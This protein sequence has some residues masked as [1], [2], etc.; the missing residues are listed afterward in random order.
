MQDCGLIDRARDYRAFSRA[1]D[2]RRMAELKPINYID[3]LAR[4]ILQD[5]NMTEGQDHGLETQKL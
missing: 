2:K 1:Y 5:F 3:W 4:L